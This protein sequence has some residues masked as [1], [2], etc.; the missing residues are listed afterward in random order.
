MNVE[1]CLL[2]MVD[3]L[4]KSLKDHIQTVVDDKHFSKF[5]MNH[6]YYL[7]AIY[8]L[9]QPNFSDLA[10]ELKI[11]NP[12]VTTMIH[13]LSKQ[14]YVIKC[15]S[16]EDKREYHICL[17]EKG[18]AVVESEFDMYRMFVKETRDYLSAEE[19]E[20]FSFCLNKI[21]VRISKQAKDS[22]QA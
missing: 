9:N 17:T 19:F 7:E 15:Q 14:G 13:K 12:S 8:R 1:K 20:S 2:K 3:Y 6:F 11:S 21:M 4:N 5:T 10:E 22:S 18:K 16:M